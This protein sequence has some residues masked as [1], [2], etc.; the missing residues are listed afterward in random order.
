MPPFVSALVALS[1]CTLSYIRVITSVFTTTP[2]QMG[3][4]LVMSQ[5]NN[6]RFEISNPS[7]AFVTIHRAKLSIGGASGETQDPRL[8]MTVSLRK[9][10][11]AGNLVAFKEVAP[12]R[13]HICTWMAFRK[14]A[15]E[16]NERVY[17]ETKEESEVR[18]AKRLYPLSLAL[19]L[20]P[21]E[22]RFNTCREY[23]E[24]FIE[25]IASEINDSLADGVVMGF[26]C[27]GVTSKVAQPRMMDLAPAADGTPRRE[28]RTPRFVNTPFIDMDNTHAYL[29]IVREQAAQR[30]A[31]PKSQRG[32]PWGPQHQELLDIDEV[33]DEDRRGHSDDTPF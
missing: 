9:V 12:D 27:K 23:T 26:L 17:T 10:D 31:S 19:R 16:G 25:H 24:A 13:F 32:L 29:D 28:L 3:H 18:F 7:L 30:A 8:Q 11:D 15:W 33:T 20:T 1:V 2:A 6:V 4:L 5:E 21:F 14:T 22:E